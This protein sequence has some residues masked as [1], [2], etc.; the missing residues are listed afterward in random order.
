MITEPDHLIIFF[1]P[2]LGG[3]HLANLFALTGR[4]RYRVDYSKYFT[5]QEHAHFFDKTD[6]SQTISLYHF[7][8]AN[9]D[10]IDQ[11]RNSKVNFV[12]IHWPTHNELAWRR[13]EK[14]N[15]PLRT[16]RMC[17]CVYDLTKLYKQKFLEKI[18]PGNWNTVMADDLFSPNADTL[19]KQIESIAGPIQQHQSLVHDIHAAWI[20]NIIKQVA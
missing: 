11:V 16:P 13:L 8:N 1:M 19:V 12:V 9:D 6:Q 15:G 18:Y 10:L 20:N 14:L 7:G 17:D 2:G 5:G 4:Y 3:H